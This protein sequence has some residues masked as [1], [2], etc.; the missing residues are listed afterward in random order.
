M[1]KEQ[2]EKRLYELMT[3]AVKILKEFEPNSNYLTMVYLGDI[4]NGRVNIYNDAFR[5]DD[6]KPIDINDYDFNAKLKKGTDVS[7]YIGDE[8]VE[9]IAIKDDQK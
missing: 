2:A 4:G 7:V 8:Y 1:N 3:E 5:H 9:T 6:V